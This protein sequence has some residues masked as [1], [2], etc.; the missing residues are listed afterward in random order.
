MRPGLIAFSACVV[1]TACGGPETSQAN[2]SQANISNTAQPPATANN[3]AMIA[4]RPLP[5]DQALKVMH[6]RHEGMEA[7]GKNNKALHRELVSSS[8]FMPTVRSSA[9]NIAK[10]AASASGWFPLGTGPD[11]A[12]TG[13]KPEIW[14]NQAHFL[15]KLHTFQAAARAMNAAAA[16]EDVAVIKARFGAMNEACKACHDKYRSEMHH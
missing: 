5:R 8:P 14:Q 2:N 15:A 1:L 16:G 11:V 12:K 10:L 6:A 7:I 4:V 3:M 13:A 9:A